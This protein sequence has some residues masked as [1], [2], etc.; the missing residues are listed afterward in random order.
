[1]E[2]IG[3]PLFSEEGGGAG[4]FWQLGNLAIMGFELDCQNFPATPFP[5]IKAKLDLASKLFDMEI[6]DVFSSNL[7]TKAF[8]FSKSWDM[9]IFL[10]GLRINYLEFRRQ[11]F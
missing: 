4:K 6:I 5:V 2:E 9:H 1:L 11:L 3:G 7:S 8:A 10:F